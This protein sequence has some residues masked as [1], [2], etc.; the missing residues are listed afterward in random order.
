MNRGTCLIAGVIALVL[1]A[2][3]QVHAAGQAPVKSI[4]LGFVSEKPQPEIEGRFQDF[5]RYVGQK[6]SVETKVVA[7]PTVSQL[8]RLLDE[9]KVDFYMDSPYPTYL[10][11]RQGAARLLLRRW[12]SGM[13]EYHSIIFAKKNSRVNGLGDLKGKIIAFEDPGSTSAYFLPKVFLLKKGFQLTEKPAPESKLLPKETGYIFTYSTA[14]TVDLVLSDKAAAGA[15]SNDD[16]EGIDE[17]AKAQIVKLGETESLPR[18][19]VSIRKDLDPGMAKRLKETLSAMQND[20]EGR[21]ILAQTDGT[22][23]FD[24]LPGGEEAMRRRLVELFRPRGKN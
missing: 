23:K 5:M 2:A 24:L 21:K 15:F 13:A 10:V 9:K 17:K 19:L 14:K 12:K 16:Y 22:T 20:E 6:L 7:A 4:T 3:A 8:T 11:N 1:G 18:S